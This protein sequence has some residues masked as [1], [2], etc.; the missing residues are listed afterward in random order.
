MLAGAG[1]TIWAGRRLRR[2]VERYLPAQ[3]RSDVAA[4]LRAAGSDLREAID[5]GRA[6]MSEREAELRVQLHLAP[7]PRGASP[8]TPTPPAEH[9]GGSGGRGEGRA[10]QEHR[11]H[12]EHR[13]PAVGNDPGGGRGRSRQAARPR[14]RVV[15]G[16]P[17]DAPVGRPGDAPA[18]RRATDAPLERHAAEPPPGGRRGDPPVGGPR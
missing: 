18:G 12:Q 9:S 13:E 6:A 8:G 14:L 17:G 10:T 2:R 3:L 11:E 1:G 15:G 4:R 16:R 5:D 7:P